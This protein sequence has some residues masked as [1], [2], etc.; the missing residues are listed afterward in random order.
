MSYFSAIK[1]AI[2]IFPL[3]ILILWIPFL[4]FMYHKYGSVNKIRVFIIYSF[5]LYMITIYF[6]V[7]LPLPSKEK[8]MKMPNIEPILIPF[9]FIKE[10]INESSFVIT[11]PNTYLK[12]L[13]EPCIYTVVFNIFMTVPFGMY[14]RYYFKCN[15]KKVI[16]FSFLLSLFFELTQLTGLYY[17]YPKPY[18]VFDVDDLIM[19]TL[20]GIIG[21][22]MMGYLTKVLPTREEID[23]KSL[24]AGRKVS[25]FRRITMFCFDFFIY[26]FITIFISIFYDNDY[27]KYII[28]IIYYL[29]FPY[30]W[31]GQTIGSKFL[32]I[33]INYYDNK[34]IKILLRSLFIHIYYFF[35]PYGLLSTLTNIKHYLNTSESILIYL[36]SFILIVVFYLAN[37]ITIIRKKTIYYD[38]I[39]KIEYQSTIRIDHNNKNM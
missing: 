13:F 35:L 3:I 11:D 4:L 39:F 17:I 29:I 15:I 21:Y 27:L 26:T 32:N 10:I 30:F 5:I 33:K 24:E 23:E 9:S 7:I 36:I 18:R 8:L 25:P 14:L 1:T 28:Y 12:S 20:G 31:D 38:K 16:I 6:L 34:F 2:L 19:N 22:V 37:I